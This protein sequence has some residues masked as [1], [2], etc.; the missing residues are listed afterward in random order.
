MEGDTWGIPGPTFA[1]GYAVAVVITG[2]V[3]KALRAAAQ[4]GRRPTTE[5]LLALPPAHVAYLQGGARLAA[6]LTVLGLSRNGVI[7]TDNQLGAIVEG[8][9]ATISKA[10]RLSVTERLPGD[11]TALER[12]AVRI[13]A[14]DPSIPPSRLQHELRESPEM[15]ALADDL[16]A[17][18]LLSSRGSR[19]VARLMALAWLPTLALGVARL[20]AGL[21]AGRPILFL[22]GELTAAAVWCVV[23]LVYAPRVPARVRA[24][25]ASARS[26]LGVKGYAKRPGLGTTGHFGT[27]EAVAVALWG[28]AVIWVMD[29]VSATLLSMPRVDPAGLLADG[30][31][32]TSTSGCGGDSGCGGGCGGCG[33]CGG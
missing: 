28:T 11:A 33:G 2:L 25:L 21:E 31:G 14:D 15:G 10:S 30:R 8:S 7:S 32:L 3:V 18:G 20:Q 13:V 27:E 6:A 22:V 24:R 12:A 29:P 1:I 26:E 23:N 5:Q 9:G 19:L 17:R 16:T 4:P